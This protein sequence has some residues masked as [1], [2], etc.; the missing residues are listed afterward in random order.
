[1]YYP[2]NG[3]TEELFK[4][5]SLKSPE[6]LAEKSISKINS[7]KIQLYSAKKASADSGDTL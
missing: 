3:D 5:S 2:K 1:M 4:I 6:L 7:V